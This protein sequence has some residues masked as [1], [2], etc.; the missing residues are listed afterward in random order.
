MVQ[1]FPCL[2]LYECVA[3]RGRKGKKEINL[4]HSTNRD[5]GRLTAVVSAA[6][7]P[8]SYNNNMFLRNNANNNID[9]PKTLEAL[10]CVGGDS[11]GPP[12]TAAPRHLGPRPP[13]WEQAL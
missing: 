3:E 5:G 8:A 1:L 13:V 9:P 4:L 7:P 11:A 6:P 12:P 10:G 2:M